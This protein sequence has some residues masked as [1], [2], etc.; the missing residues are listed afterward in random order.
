M[1][2]QEIKHESIL[3]SDVFGY[4]MLTLDQSSQQMGC[5]ISRIRKSELNIPFL[6]ITSCMTA[7]PVIFYYFRCTVK[8]SYYTIML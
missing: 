5:I 8:R 3:C 1:I 6:H 4:A 7:I 2:F